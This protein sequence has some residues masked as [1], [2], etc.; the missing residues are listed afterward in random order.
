MVWRMAAALALAAG[1]SG[2]VRADGDGEAIER[3]IENQMEAFR[4]GDPVAAFEFASPTIRGLF[5]TPEN[6]GRM[7]ATGY[8]PIWQ[9]GA[10]RFLG[11][12]ERGGRLQQRV[13]VTGPQGR[14]HLFDYEMIP[15]EAGWK[16]NGV[17]PVAGA[18]LGV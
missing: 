9:P 13:E 7:V 17:R 5:G 4:A 1:L 10:V 11:L 8:P 15:T 18:E 3:V 14:T 16:I 12:T 6:F 2:P